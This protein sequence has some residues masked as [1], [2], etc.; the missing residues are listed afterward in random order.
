MPEPPHTGTAL[1]RDRRSSVRRPIKVAATLDFNAERDMVCEIADF[2][3]EGVY[4]TYPADTAERLQRLR[5]NCEHV[6]GLNFEDSFGH[7]PYRMNVAVK[8]FAP[9]AF[10]GMFI[11]S[12]TAAI[13]SLL[14]MCGTESSPDAAAAMQPE[15]AS[16]LMRQIER[17]VINHVEP[18]FDSFIAAL[19]PAFEEAIDNAAT[20]NQKAE[21]TDAILELAKQSRGLKSSYFNIL[22]DG[23]VPRFG[24][25]GE[26]EQAPPNADLSLIDKD[27]FEDWLTLKVMVTK[28]E[29]ACGEELLKLKLR[30][31][32]LGFQST[33][34]YNLPVSPALVCYA[35]RDALI[36]YNLPLS[37]ERLCLKC[38]EETVVHQLEVM[39][40]E[41]NQ[42]MIRQGVLPDLNLTKVQGAQ[43]AVQKT[44]DE[45]STETDST[46]DLSPSD[47]SEGALG[48]EPASVSA[49]VSSR[50]PGAERPPSAIAGRP[51]RAVPNAPPAAPLSATANMA[52]PVSSE[53]SAAAYYSAPADAAVTTAASDLASTSPFAHVGNYLATAKESVA[54]VNNLLASLQQQ[55]Q[56]T[57]LSTATE[58]VFPS[59]SEAPAYQNEEV[60][61][62]LLQVQ[63]Q[64]EVGNGQIENGT[65]RSR[66]AG[67][68][69]QEQVESKAFTPEQDKTLDVVDRFFDSLLKNRKLTDDSKLQIKGMEVPLVRLLLR[70]PDFFEDASHPAR[71]FMDRLAQVGVKGARMSPSQVKRINGLV[72]RIQ[73]EHEQD[74]GVFDEALAEVDEIVERQNLLY[75]RN[76]ERVM[77]AA[78]GQQKVE[79]SKREVAKAIHERVAGRKVPKA[80][81]TLLSGGWRDLLGLTYIRQGPDSQAWQ[82]YLNVIDVLIRVG[83]GVDFKFNLP[84]LLKII[85][86]GLSTISSNHLPSG[87]VRDEIK[88]LLVRKPDDAPPELTEIPSSP[89]ADLKPDIGL[90]KEARERGLQRWLK[91]AKKINVGDWLKLDRDEKEPELI[92]LVWVAKDFA[93]YVFVNHQGM[94]VIDLDALTLAAYLQKG[95]A[96]NEPD[97]DKPVVDESLDNMVKDLYEQISHVG[98]HDEL[99]GLMLRK[100]FERQLLVQQSKMAD[101]EIISCLLVSLQ[102]FHSI[103]DEA[104]NDAGD[105][106]LKELAGQFK[107]TLPGKALLSRYSSDEYM[108]ALPESISTWLPVIRSLLDSY[109]FN[110]EGADYQVLAA[111]GYIETSPA[112]LDTRE[113][114]RAAEG[115][116]RQARKN[117]IGKTQAYNLTQQQLDQREALSQKIADLDKGL[118]GDRMLV[119][120]QKVM[121]LRKAT[122]AGVHHEILLSIYD[123]RGR[124][125][126]VSDFVHASEDNKPMQDVDRWTVSYILD[127]MA[128]KGDRLN[129]IGG[130]SIKLSGHSLNDESLLEFIF[131]SISRQN[132]PLE[133]LTFEITQAEAIERIYDVS[134]FIRELQEYGCGFCLACYG[135]GQVSYELLNELPVDMIKVDDSYVRDLA[136]D[137]N[138]Q[139][140][141]RSMIEMAH[142]KKCEVLMPGVETREAFRELKKAGADYAQGG[143]IERPQPLAKL[144]PETV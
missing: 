98:T 78:E 11:E 86:D 12:N 21:L 10:G 62:S 139:L 105:K 37:A 115:S 52:Q 31:D 13:T 108:I 138:D 20:N 24:R 61:G 45:T 131:E 63:T 67:L 55:R 95:I 26:E 93:R 23:L 6:V 74:A 142:Y 4:I 91:R 82:D 143:L 71:K 38:F 53:P 59:S 104:G 112:S 103:N 116:C 76:V 54:T 14:R 58:T 80:V 85:Q 90:L 32:A 70:N 64:P 27:E 8:R 123:Q 110:W 125:V 102:Q 100:E 57:G 96:V 107:A 44:L 2:C 48:A 79:E 113:L 42:L 29:A 15:T 135:T 127:W 132:Y 81:A 136:T 140:M 101:E 34:G 68:V 1:G 28:A 75:R 128:E 92:R 22:S 51:L 5:L 7:R 124:L 84:E 65:L 109:H 35:L 88:G 49:P 33:K 129:K 77:A 17:A 122:K 120:S 89:E 19:R 94:K 41:L 121:P 3:P 36:Q 66:L 39:Y 18:L 106:I 25:D 40:S 111:V 114:L 141:V 87:F 72:S 134:E 56:H 69:E 9:G 50:T 60:L 144:W 46:Q 47:G 73:T 99:T 133:K 30:F 43:G 126:P 83:S 16:L 137:K 130:I 97:V 118:D 119:Q 117:G